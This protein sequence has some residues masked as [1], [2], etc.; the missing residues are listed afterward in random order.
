M[1]NV[2]RVLFWSD[3]VILKPKVTPGD[4]I[5]TRTS[6]VFRY[7]RG[8]LA[9]CPTYSKPCLYKTVVFIAF[10][11]IGIAFNSFPLFILLFKVQGIIFFIIS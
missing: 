9:P 4:T 7:Y 6:N 11:I 5:H 8:I 10:I 2:Q 3:R 1:L